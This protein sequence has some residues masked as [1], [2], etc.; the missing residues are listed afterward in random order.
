MVSGEGSLIVPNITEGE[1]ASWE[2]V[3]YYCI[4]TDNIGFDVAVRSRTI[5]VFYACESKSCCIEL[6]IIL[7]PK[8]LI[9]FQILMDLNKWRSQ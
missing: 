8:V 5:T 4:A 2:G 1:Y 3:E 9:T 7:S 6:T